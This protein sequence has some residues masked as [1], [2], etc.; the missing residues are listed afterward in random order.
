[1]KR[2]VARPRARSERGECGG[3]RGEFCG[4][5]IE[6]VEEDAVE[7]EVGHEGE[8]VVGGDDD[9]VGVR[10]GLAGEIY[11]GAGVLA[12]GA[13]GTEAAVRL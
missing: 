13:E 10:G 1:M 2:E 6:G 5:G 3:V 11:T 7:A 9:L 4:G 12:D 8:T